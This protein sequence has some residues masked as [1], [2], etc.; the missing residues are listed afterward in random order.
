MPDD[1]NPTARWLARGVWK[2]VFTLVLTLIGFA[3]IGLLVRAV[4]G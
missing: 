3:L 4:T 1:V 2:F